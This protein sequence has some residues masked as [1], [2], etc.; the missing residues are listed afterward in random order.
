MYL[1]TSFFRNWDQYLR[2]NE[3]VG[4]FP[5]FDISILD[6]ISLMLYVQGGD[7]AFNGKKGCGSRLAGVCPIHLT[8]VLAPFNEV[9]LD[10]DSDLWILNRLIYRYRVVVENSI[11]QIKLW[12]IVKDPYRGKIDDQPFLW[13]V[14]SRL[15]AYIMR[16][17][18]AYP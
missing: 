9:E 16:V 8:D 3:T 1:L 13:V 11:A 18:N 10:A 2:P 15:T 4:R 6:V 17:R 12:R 5:T 14:A 7:N